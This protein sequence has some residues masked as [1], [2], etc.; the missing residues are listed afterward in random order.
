MTRAHVKLLGPCFK[1]D[2]LAQG[3]DA[4]IRSLG[5]RI[6]PL[7]GGV[8]RPGADPD[9][10]YLICSPSVHQRVGTTIHPGVSRD[11][12][13]P[14]GNRGT[15][16]GGGRGESRAEPSPEPYRALPPRWERPNAQ[17]MTW[18]NLR[19]PLSHDLCQPFA[20]EQFH[21]LLNSL[22]KVLFNFPSRYLFAIGLVGIFSLGWSIPPVLSCTH[23]QLDSGETP[24]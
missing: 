6:L 8:L 5:K 4:T 19:V 7:D 1:T 9:D 23:K 14:H 3:T 2:R 12:S 24:A 13:L 20:S 17:P 16:C 11:V 21:A 15:G 18:P 22:F 10:Q